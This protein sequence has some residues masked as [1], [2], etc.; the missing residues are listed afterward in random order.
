MKL[1]KKKSKY[2]FLFTLLGVCILI[3]V[4]WILAETTFKQ[5]GIIPSPP[6]T[7]QIAAE[8]MQ[9]PDFFKAIFSTLLRSLLSFLVSFAAAAVFALLAHHKK[10][11]GKILNPFI[12]ICRAVPTVALVLILLLTVGSSLLP[13]VVSFL[14]VF[15]LCYEHM[16]TAFSEVDPKL[17]NMAKVFKMPKARQISGIYIPAMLPY[18][19]SSL[20][21][22]FGLNIKVVIS[23]EVLGLPT[24]SI[25]YLISNANAGLEWGVAFAWLVIAV[26]LSL[27]CEGILRIVRRLCMP[28]KYPD[29]KLV[30]KAFAK[31]FKRRA[32][33]APQPAQ[34]DKE[35]TPV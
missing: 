6:K 15:P 11:V 35:D 25:G 19:F 27:V 8:Q 17:I 10:F 29:L 4:W 32:K 5:T 1:R 12:A 24:L 16:H 23:A 9:K 30:K 34:D 33:S 26:F 18:V 31:I 22:G 13:A 21:A 20:I 7:L 2:D 14:V 3:A 28:Y